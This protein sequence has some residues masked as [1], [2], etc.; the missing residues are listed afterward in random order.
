MPYRLNPFTGGMDY[1]EES[2]NI[3]SIPPANMCRVKNIY[4]DPSTNKTIVK[5]EDVPGGEEYSVKS[6]PPEGMCK[7]VNVYVDP[8]TERTIVKYEGET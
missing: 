4:V 7:V 3:V 2:S 6:D 1:Y 8:V 5:W